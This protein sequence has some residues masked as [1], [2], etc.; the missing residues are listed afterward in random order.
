MNNE[1]GIKKVAQRRQ[2][3]ILHGTAKDQS[4]DT[5]FA[6]NIDIVAYGVATQVTGIELS[7][8][9]EDKGIKVLDCVL[10]TK[11][12]HAWTLSYRVTIRACDYE[13]S[14]DASIWPYRIGVR[15]FKN[16]KSG[17]QNSALR[18]NHQNTK[19]NYD[20]SIR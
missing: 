4:R 16:A 11:Y 6:A 14:Q 15:P 8:F 18:R 7:K 20:N 17:Y 10:L 19:Q 12:E 13:K 3:G 1:K 5:T 2:N 9:I